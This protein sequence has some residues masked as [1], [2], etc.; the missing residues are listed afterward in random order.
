MRWR[1]PLEGRIDGY[2]VYASTAPFTSTS[3]AVR[4]NSEMLTGVTFDHLPAAD[5]TNYYRAVAINYLRT[6]SLPSVEVSALSDRT[7]P[8]ADRI[9][10]Q[11]TG[12]ASGNRFGPGLV[13]LTVSSMSRSRP[14]RSSA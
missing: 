5:G 8:R 3:E 6:P 11:T 12:T 9:L 1:R 10:Y 7:A 14:R 2:H 4:V 13:G